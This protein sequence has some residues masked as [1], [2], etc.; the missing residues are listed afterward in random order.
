M[1][2]SN[3]ISKT[4]SLSR[5][6]INTNTDNVTI[7]DD[8]LIELLENNKGPQG[9]QGPQGP[10][11]KLV[12]I[13]FANDTTTQSPNGTGESNAIKI[14]FGSSQT[15]TNIDLDNNGN[16]IFKENGSYLIHLKLQYGRKLTSNTILLHNR[17][18]IDFNNGIGPVQFE[19]SISIEINNKKLVVP[20]EISF[21]LNVTNAPYTLYFQLMRD[22]SQTDDGGLYSFI[23]TNSS[24][25]A[26][27]SASIT[28]EKFI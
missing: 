27:S 23:P 16:F 26:S 22:S 1:S 3:S 25:Y 28:I 15:T 14:K 18:M 20:T 2:R 5:L 8:T 13:F 7:G 10:S 24:W 9:P 11:V 19:D 17:T 6:N 12:H 21:G 4:L